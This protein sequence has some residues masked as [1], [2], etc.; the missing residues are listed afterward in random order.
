MNIST[1]NVASCAVLMP[2][3]YIRTGI[4]NLCIIKTNSGCFK[5]NVA[6]C[7]VHAQHVLLRIHSKSIRVL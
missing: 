6:S 2:H 5:L 1:I 3:T 7:A 4:I